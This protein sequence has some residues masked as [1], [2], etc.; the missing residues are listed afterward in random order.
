MRYPN[1]V[2]PGYVKFLNLHGGRPKK[3]MKIL[4]SPSLPASYPVPVRL[5][6]AGVTKDV[7]IFFMTGVKRALKVYTP[8]FLAM[9]LFSLTKPRNHT[10]AKIARA[11]S[12][13]IVNIIRSSVFLS[14]YC[15]IAWAVI[16]LA[17]YFSSQG[18]TRVNLR[19]VMWAAGLS[20]LLERKE[21]RPELA[22]YCATYALDT[23]WRR[24]ELAH[25]SCKKLQPVLASICLVFSCS[26][27]LHHYNKQP[28]LV[29]KWV[30]GF[31][32]DD[33]KSTKE[34][35]HAQNRESPNF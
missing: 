24:L 11:F 35:I 20:T 28:A 18:A 7:A 13:L 29:T 22:A 3:V 9:F 27:L 8:L 4:N 32:T 34:R 16:D 2:N 6:G 14:G 5:P 21:R 31:N 10:W 26:V 19:R 17:G 25:P 15:T 30:L 1:E 33:Q 23:V 12:H